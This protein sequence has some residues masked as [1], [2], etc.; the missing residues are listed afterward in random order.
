[1]ELN[2]SISIPADIGLGGGESHAWSFSGVQ[3]YPLTT[4]NSVLY[5]PIKDIRLIVQNEVVHALQHCTKFRTIDQHLETLLAAIP[6]LAKNSADT[7]NV[8]NE[9]SKSGFGESTE[10]AWS[11]LT[12]NQGN[13]GLSATESPTKLIILTCD[14]PKAL[15]RLIRQMQTIELP[16]VVTQVIVIDDSRTEL[17]VANNHSCLCEAQRHFQVPLLHFG[18]SCRDRFLL[19][20]KDAVPECHQALDFLLSRARWGQAPTYG[21]ARNLA[22]LLSA[23]H[24]VL[25][26][27]DDIEPIC[28]APPLNS[29]ELNFVSPTDMEAAFFTSREAMLASAVRIGGNPFNNMLEKLGNTLGATLEK[30]GVGHKILLGV[31]SNLIERLHSGSKIISSQCGTWGDP[32][33]SGNNWVFFQSTESIER[34]L[35][36]GEPEDSLSTRCC[37]VGHGG[38][39]ISRF[40]LKS[41]ITGIDNRQLLPPYIPAGRGEDALFGIMLERMHPES[42]VFEEGWA[43]SHQP[44]EDRTQSHGLAPVRATPGINVLA[45]WLGR[46][47]K[48]SI[49][50]DALE[51]LFDIA[52]DISKLADLNKDDSEKIVRAELIRSSAS[53]LDRCMQHITSIPKTEGLPGGESWTTFLEKN[54]GLLLQDIQLPRA[55]PLNEILQSRGTTL[56]TLQNL[57]KDFS[58]ALRMWPRIIEAAASYDI[59]TRMSR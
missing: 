13:L 18:P 57:G 35:A 45:N 50:A 6:Q 3:I 7:R 17:A 59:P 34:L 27:D 48:G 23:N 29:R 14:R 11:R 30:S 54:R 38:P 36:M 51:N 58:N 26:V 24:R 15:E 12:H 41:C 9:I 53:L 28:V 31:E 20:L 22:L 10:T 2:H 40:G 42:A 56:E 44:V 16:S 21:L 8:I 32:G 47:A 39:G 52:N 43:I 33:T 1:M 46:G 5:E 55:E 37:W 49:K 19:Y 4:D 25:I